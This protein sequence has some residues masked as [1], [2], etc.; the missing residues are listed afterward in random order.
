MST[1]IKQV[2]AEFGQDF[3]NTFGRIV[4][5]FMDTCEETEIAVN[6]FTS[7]ADVPKRVAEIGEDLAALVGAAR[8]DVASLLISLRQAIRAIS[9]DDYTD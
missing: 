4:C 8:Y 3:D 7:V 6:E 9:A 2:V 1:T 5:R